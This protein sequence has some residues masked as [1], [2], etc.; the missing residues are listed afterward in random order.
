MISFF[1]KHHS[2][3]KKKKSTYEIYIIIFVL[4]K[5]AKIPSIYLLKLGKEYLD[6][7]GLL[8]CIYSH[9]DPHINEH[10]PLVLI[11]K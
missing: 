2:C 11:I 7:S 8:E 3:R 5:M 9:V 4:R 6:L 1:H 10:T